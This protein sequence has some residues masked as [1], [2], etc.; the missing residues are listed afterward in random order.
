MA[1]GG[2]IMS[3]G[4]HPPYVGPAARFGSPRARDRRQRATRR[5]KDL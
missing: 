2:Q 4:D 5:D 1:V 3:R